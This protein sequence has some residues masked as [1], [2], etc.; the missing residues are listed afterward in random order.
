MP[1]EAVTE[2]VEHA[3]STVYDALARLTALGL[4]VR[5]ETGGHRINARYFF[6]ANP[7]LRRVIAAP[8]ADP[9]ITPDARAEAPRKLTRRN[10]L[11]SRRA[12][13]ES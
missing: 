3:E 8:L 10:S 1:M 9:P 2:D 7:D 11:Y 13:N 5:D 12:D 6:S 4:L